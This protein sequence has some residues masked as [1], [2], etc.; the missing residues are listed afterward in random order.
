MARHPIDLGVGDALLDLR[1]FGRGARIALTP[2]QARTIAYTVRRAPEVM[3]KV[4]GGARTLGGVRAHFAYI[5]RDGELGVEDDHGVRLDGQGFEKQLAPDWDLDLLAHRR[6]DQRS[7]LGKRRAPKLVHNSIFSMPPGTPPKKVLAA[8]RKLAVNEFAFKHRYVLVLHTD[9]A[10]PHM[11]LVVKA[12]S[13][14]G[15]RLNIR[16]ATLRDWRQQFA[17]NLQERGIAANA[18]ERAVRGES[19]TPK[20]DG[21]YRAAQRGEST[22]QIQELR[23]LRA[24]S[25]RA[26]QRFVRGEQTLEDT[27]AVVVSGWRAIARELEERGAFQLAGNVYDFV[28]GC[29]RRQQIRRNWLANFCHAAGARAWIRW[30]ER[31]SHPQLILVPIR[32]AS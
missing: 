9:E 21:I 2:K 1:S 32:A 22:R 7:I 3:V 14:Q 19:R 30:T 25:E 17:E 6:Q 28:P 16:K 26:A 23:D 11:H 5:S 13:E 8:V 15:E 24:R 10:H 4:S 29:R 12:E 20:K 18:T 31:F 27:R